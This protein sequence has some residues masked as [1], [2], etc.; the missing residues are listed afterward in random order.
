M[1]FETIKIE[2]GNLF[3]LKWHNQRLNQSRQQLFGLSDTLNLLDYLEHSPQSG[4]YRCK[5]IYNSSIQSVEYFPYT[6]KK[7]HSFKVVPSNLDYGFK[8]LDRTELDALHSDKSDEVIIEKEG[9]LTDTSIANIAVFDGQ[10][11]LTPES[12]LLQ[13]TTRARLLEENFLSLHTIR[14]ENLK[15]YSHFA[16]M[17]SMIGFSIQKSTHFIL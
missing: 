12:P 17:N 5:V 9:L 15:N 13:G 8:Y 2:D 1:L 3:N 16:L 14:K 6:P 10:R 11:W 4:L 7:F